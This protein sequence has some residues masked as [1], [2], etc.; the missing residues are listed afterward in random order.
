VGV[1][2]G[3][4]FV[5]VVMR[6]VNVHDYAV[7]QTSR[8]GIIFFLFDI[9]MSLVQKL[10]GLVQASG[11][12]IV[13]V[14]GSVVFHVL[15]VL[16]CSALDFVNGVVDFFNSSALFSVQSASVGTLQVRSR[17]PQIRKRVQVGWMLALRAYI[18]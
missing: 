1:D 5:H 3:N 17:I 4:G 15:A 8:F 9:V 16:E 7:S 6:S 14:D 13:R 11:P 2:N 18:L 12:R 10:A